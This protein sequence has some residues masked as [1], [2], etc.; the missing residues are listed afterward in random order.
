MSRY[1]VRRLLLLIPLLL[2]IT[3]LSYLLINLAPGDPITML[4]NP[5][6]SSISTGALQRRREA[7][8]LGDPLP[9]R[10]MRW[11]GELVR[12]NLGYS[13][14]TNR[15]VI[16]ELSQRLV[17]T[18]QLMVAALAISLIVGIIAGVLAALR[19]YSWLDY[20]ITLFAFFGISM[21][22]FF[23]GLSLIYLLSLKLEIL[24]TGGMNTLGTPFSITDRL[25][26]LVMPALVLSL[27][28]TA[29]VFRYTRT[30]LLEI[31]HQDFVRTARAKG[32]PER[33]VIGVH[34]LRNALL[35]VLTVI[36]LKIPQLMGGAIITEEIF[37]W[38]GMGTLSLNAVY[39]RDYP[40]ILGVTLVSAIVV[41]LVNLFTDIA[42]AFADPRVR[43]G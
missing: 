25:R 27:F 2:G 10:Y 42:Y 19:Q 30:S 4:I 43:Y 23:F 9:I 41:V 14:A 8:G 21:P 33:I 17:A 37:Q 38:P 13:Y 7:L 31:L 11:L 20:G 6:D 18:L 5:A 15:P 22:S 1:I 40:V 35:P 29:E 39:Q 3:L 12:G 36:G 16:Q 24:P 32:L 34:A 26:H 28:H